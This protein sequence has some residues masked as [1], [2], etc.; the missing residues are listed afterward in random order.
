MT[1]KNDDKELVEFLESYLRKGY[2]I[3]GTSTN[4]D[5]AKY[6]LIQNGTVKLLKK[7]RILFYEY[8]DCIVISRD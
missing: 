6:L 5:M 1:D 4:V 7:K 8:D 2:K 3:N